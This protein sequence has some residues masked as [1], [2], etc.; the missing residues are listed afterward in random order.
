MTKQPTTTADGERTYTCKDCGHQK[1]EPIPKLTGDHTHSYT[2][3]VT[4]PTCTDAGYTTHTCS[5]GDSYKDNWT[6]PA[7][8]HPEWKH[9]ETEHWQECVCG[10]KTLSE[11][12]VWN[13]S[14]ATA[15]HAKYCLVCGYVAE[16]KQSAKHKITVIGGTAAQD[17]AAEGEVVALTAD[18]AP[19]GK[20][21]K[22][23]KLVS[24]NAVIDDSQAAATSLTMG[25]KPVRIEAVFGNP[26][27]TEHAVRFEAGDG[28][29]KPFVEIAQEGT[30][31]V[32]P[33][34]PFTP[35]ADNLEFDLW[36]VDGE[37][38]APG[39]PCDITQNITITPVWKEKINEGGGTAPDEG[40]SGGK[41]DEGGSGEKPDTDDSGSKPGAGS[42]G[43]TSPAGGSGNPPQTAAVPKAPST[44]DPVPLRPWAVTATLALA[45]ATGIKLR[46][47]KNAKR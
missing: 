45:G 30:D 37:L 35:P 25:S 42:P 7:G 20:E 26:A 2:S 18:S 38:L 13:T 3:I 47:R 34:C 8:H 40:G 15:H 29:G 21:F 22:Y 5:C 36:N 41:P 14:L 32:L 11:A 10:N 16:E 31:Y 23:W 39:T 4:M 1:K 43:G 27:G 46:K 33:D 28:S 19:T 12:H 17:L 6:P 9:S 24:G 44:G